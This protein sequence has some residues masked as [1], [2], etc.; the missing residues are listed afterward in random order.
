LAVASAGLPVRPPRIGERNGD[1]NF[2]L[3]YAAAPIAL[4]SIGIGAASGGALAAAPTAEVAKK[5]AALMA[6]AFPPRVLGNPAAGST[7]GSGQAEQSFFRK[8]LENGG[9]VEVPAPSGLTPMPPERP[10]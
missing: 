2:R 8:C 1:M 3:T 6:Q 7:R 10:R 5:C 4:V 9:T